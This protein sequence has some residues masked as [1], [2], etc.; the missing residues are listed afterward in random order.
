MSEHP[1]VFISYS[2]QNAEYEDRILEFA[3]HLRS[4]GI[5]ANID[6][7]EEAPAE[8]WP[9]WM[10]NQINNSDFVLVVNSKS[11]YEKCYSESEKG[12]GISWEIN[13]VYQ[14]IYDASTINTKFIPV[15]FEKEEEQ[16]ILTPL[17]SFTFY[18]IGED[19]G[20]EKL[21]WR[22]RGVSKA[23]KP[24][25]GNLRP[26]PEKEKKTM[27]FSSPIDLE[28]WDAAK[29]RGMLYL[30]SPGSAPVLG[31]LFHNYVAAKSIF[32]DWK[33]SANNNVA[34]EFI[35]VDYIIPPFPRD[36]WVY[37]D[38]ERNY[39]K[40]YFVH[41]GPNAEES[42]NRALA[43]GL[44]SEELFVAT[45]SRYQWMDELKGSQNRDLFRHLTDHGSGY[46]LMPIGT[47]DSS[48]AIEEN[49]LIIDF[50]YAIG[51]KKVTFRTGLEIGD[52]DLCKL[53][54][55]KAEEI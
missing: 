23:Q 15:F 29:W 3:N 53:V 20:F 9:R 14:Y 32:I 31:L 2:H 11:Y 37:T 52:N 26:L 48:K 41:I 40:G 12:K 7:Y 54:L 28:K 27:F 30:F 44:Q 18:N 38:K 21:Y 6:L 17:K 4:E 1:K 10:E 42:I 55:S 19:D 43:S 47:K 5:D 24:P 22:L 13:I 8:G 39:G 33:K 51:M 50:N 45:I 35:K 34:D 49:N 16:Y 25:L 46:L 36:C